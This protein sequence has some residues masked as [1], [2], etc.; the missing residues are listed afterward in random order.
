M[1]G[2]CHDWNVLRSIEELNL[3]HF[4]RFLHCLNGVNCAFHDT[5]HLDS[6]LHL[7]ERWYLLLYPLFLRE[8]NVE[9]AESG[10]SRPA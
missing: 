5:W 6:L 1:I 7:L 3:W 2:T 8:K 9:C 4:H 10:K